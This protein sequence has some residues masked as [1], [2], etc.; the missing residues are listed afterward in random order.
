MIVEHAGGGKE[1]NNSHPLV[2]CQGES[3]KSDVFYW[4]FVDRFDFRLLSFTSEIVWFRRR[5][6]LMQRL[7]CVIFLQPQL[8]VLT[9]EW[10]TKGCWKTKHSLIHNE[11]KLCVLSWECL[12]SCRVLEAL[13]GYRYWS[14]CVQVFLFFFSFS[15]IREGP[16]Y[17]KG[18][19]EC[20]H[21]VLHLLPH[22]PAK[23]QIPLELSQA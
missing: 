17:W 21:L 1:W 10:W 14:R 16:S 12:T 22:H 13:F 5:M 15:V 11:P 20:I 19:A 8:S 7:L 4:V 9:I 23:I 3:L 2:P 6:R 18:R